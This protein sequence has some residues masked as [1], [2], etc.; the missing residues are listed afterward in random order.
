MS[1]LTQ[2]SKGKS[3]IACGVND[4]TICARHYNGVRQQHYG[5]G[6]RKKCHDLMTAELCMKCD[7][8][9]SEGV[10]PSGCETKWDRSEL[11]L[12]YIALTNIRRYEE[13]VIKDG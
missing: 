7:A 10:M 2:S 12:H 5:K 11:F 9:L 3:C 8:E 1:K 4:G 13:G 6:M